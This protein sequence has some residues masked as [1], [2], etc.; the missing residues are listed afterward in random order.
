MTWTGVEATLRFPLPDNGRE[1]LDALHGGEYLRVLQEFED[2]LHGIEVSENL[3]LD[4]QAIMGAVRAM[5]NK[6]TDGIE[7]NED[8]K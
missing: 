1:L 4:E 8:L 3:T 7:F 2:S 5:W 6:I